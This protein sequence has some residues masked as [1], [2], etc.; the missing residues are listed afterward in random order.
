MSKQFRLRNVISGN[1]HWFALTIALLTV[2]IVGILFTV[3][4]FWLLILG[5]VISGV[6]EFAIREIPPDT[7]NY[8]KEQ[9]PLWDAA[10]GDGTESTQ[11]Y[12][13]RIRDREERK[14]VQETDIKQTDKLETLR[15]RYVSGELTEE[16][17][18]HKLDTYIETEDAE[19]EIRR[20][21]RYQEDEYEL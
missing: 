10:F 4:W 9:Y 11:E 5:M 19:D 7:A 13:E 18:E 14:T 12:Q 8:G 20:E 21:R 16:Q 1:D 17:F 15:E 6:V 2:A 3:P